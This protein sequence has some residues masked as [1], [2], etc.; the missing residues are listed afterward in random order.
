MNKIQKAYT[1]AF[2]S[3]GI[4]GTYS[5]ALKSAGIG[6]LKKKKN[7]KPYSR[8]FQSTGIGHF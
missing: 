3:A 7:S 2:K 1:N 4:G 5:N 8:G 6:H